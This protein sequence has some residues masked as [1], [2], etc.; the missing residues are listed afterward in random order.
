LWIVL[1]LDASA[2]S[3]GRDLSGTYDVGTLTPLQRPEALGD[4]LYLSPEQAEKMSART[5]R[6]LE[7]D[8][9]DSD[10]NRDAP[11]VKKQ[12]TTGYNYF[13]L[14][15]GSSAVNL[16]GQFR[17]SILTSPSNG[18]IPPM[19]EQGAARMQG[20]LSSWHIIWRNPDP[21]T[22]KDGSTAWWLEDGNPDG[23]YDHLEQRPMSE[24]CLLGSR[25]TA[26]PPLLPN[27]YNNHK[28]IVQSPD[29]VMILTEMIHDARIIRMNA[30]HRPAHIRTWLGDSVGHWDGDVLVVETTHF[31]AT[32]ALSGADENLRVEERFE[33]LDATTL[34][35]SFV[36]EDASVWSAPWGGEYAWNSSTGKVYEFA[37]HE[38]NYA[39][40]NVMSGARQLEKVAGQ[41]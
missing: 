2:A 16:D 3:K 40:R 6:F 41:R 8:A 15:L 4:N 20:L 26:G 19:T 36:V 14:E 13:W 12:V 22:S 5:A 37:C 9:A 17:T 18:R 24:R 38:G 7:A 27:I 39:L 33:R 29:H 31:N 35:Y 23:P 1:A 11:P 34:R 25:S 21:T 30:S 10:P 32:P 28:R